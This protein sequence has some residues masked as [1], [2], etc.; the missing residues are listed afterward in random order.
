M[1]TPLSTP[2][3]PMDVKLQIALI[4]AAVSISILLVKG[5]ATFFYRKYDLRYK[6]KKEYD[7]KQKKL[8]KESLAGVKT[9]LVKAAED[10]N[11]RFWNL[12]THIDERWHNI[13]EVD[14]KKDEKY[15]L[16]SFTY[17]LLVFYFWIIESEK[18]IYKL[19]LSKAD[20]E[21]HQYLKF[22]KTLK[23][24]LCEREL[25][26]ELGYT[27]GQ[28]E[29]HFY[30][31]E[32]YSFHE[33][34]KTTSNECCSFQEFEQKYKNNHGDISKLIKYI[35]NIESSQD[36]LN[37]NA[38]KSLHIF[39]MLFLNKYGLDYHNTTDDKISKLIST[40][41]ANLRI[42]KGLAKFI[43]RN[44]VEKEAKLM[45]KKFGLNMRIDS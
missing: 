27:A 17:R 33:Y 11:Y 31:D 43:K 38:I 4:S 10:L 23:H 6:M 7:F 18:V 37:Y 45:I 9:P 2:P 26:V 35:S 3:D 21:D 8:I 24:F 14:W 16:R 13:P 5:I 22:V 44:K 28:T 34:M 19:D 1:N 20:Q 25:L 12:S 42:K 41:Y 39:I 32:V 29:H 36:N 30:K 15:Y 40:K